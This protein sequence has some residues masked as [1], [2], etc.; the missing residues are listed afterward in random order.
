MALTD[1]QIA[2]VE[3]AKMFRKTGAYSKLEETAIC[4]LEVIE[5]HEREL[6]DLRRQMRNLREVTPPATSSLQREKS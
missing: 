6:K 2:A 3:K 5:A 4:L 1:E